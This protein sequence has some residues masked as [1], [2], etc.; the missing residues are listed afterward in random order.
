[1]K[2]QALCLLDQLINE[3]ESARMSRRIRMAKTK[4]MRRLCGLVPFV[5]LVCL[6][7]GADSRS[8]WHLSVAY[9]VWMVFPLCAVVANGLLRRKGDA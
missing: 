4:F 2:D 3:S 5:G 1:M 8:A 6:L 7:L 9:E